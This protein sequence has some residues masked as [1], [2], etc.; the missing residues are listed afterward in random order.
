MY[1]V[2]V[3]CGAAILAACLAPAA[4]A[5]EW[6]KLTY[7]TF[8]APVEMPGMVLPAGSYKFE[9]ADPDS[10][11]RVV[12]ISEKEGGKIHGIFLSIPDQKLEP[13]DKPIVMFREA[14]A[15]APEA[16][17]AWFYPGETTGYEFVYPH[18]QALKIAKAMHTS[19]LTAK[20]EVTG[21]T[22]ATDTTRIDEND[23]V[24]S[25]DEQLKDSAKRA[26]TT[27]TTTSTTTASTT[28]AAAAAPVTPPPPERRLRP[29]R[30]RPR[31]RRRR[32]EAR[33][34]MPAPAPPATTTA[35]AVQPPA[36]VAPQPVTTPRGTTIT[37]PTP[38]GTSGQTAA[39]VAACPRRR[40]RSRCSSCSAVSRSPAASRFEPFGR[41][42]PSG[43]SPV[44]ANCDCDLITQV[45]ESRGRGS[46]PSSGFWTPTPRQSPYAYG[47]AG[48][49]SLT[50]KTFSPGLIRPSS[51]R[52]TSSIAL[53]SSLRRR[54]SRAGA[55]CL[56]ACARWS[57]TAASY[58]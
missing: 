52:A 43:R 7:F 35:Q 14:P 20:G 6:T 38:V 57:P 10:T 44:A 46:L 2:R 18:D 29:R 11:R 19:V 31:P 41:H 45:Q 49:T 9:L 54:A 21:T 4:Q 27:S 32:R 23:R 50:M 42:A 33:A 15:G 26:A 8:S 40:A 24:L 53:G 30:P 22:L 39:R 16:V 1:K 25:A 55:R 36:T 28:T 13:S 34:P 37:E 58:W 3:L 17:K 51:R 12:R 56:P 5:D 48:G 47:F